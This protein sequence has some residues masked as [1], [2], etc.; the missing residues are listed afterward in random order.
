M[1]VTMH[2]HSLCVRVIIDLVFYIVYVQHIYV[3][4]LYTIQCILL[5]T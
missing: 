2:A 4:A 1:E 5:Y 3:M